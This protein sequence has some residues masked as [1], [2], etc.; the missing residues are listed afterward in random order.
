MKLASVTT[1][2]ISNTVA[3]TCRL[4]KPLS[5]RITS[6]DDFHQLLSHRNLATVLDVS[7]ATIYEAEFA[8][9]LIVHETGNLWAAAKNILQNISVILSFTYWFWKNAFI[10]FAWKVA[11]WS[12]ENS[13]TERKSAQFFENSSA[14]IINQKCI[15]SFSSIAWTDWRAKAQY[16]T[17]PTCCCCC[18][19]C[20][21]RCWWW[22]VLSWTWQKQF[23][24][25]ASKH[26][27]EWNTFSQQPSVPSFIFCINIASTLC[28]LLGRIRGSA[29]RAGQST[30]GG[31]RLAQQLQMLQLRQKLLL[32]I[33][34]HPLWNIC[35][36]LLGLLLRIHSGHPRMVGKQRVPFSVKQLLQ[37]VSCLVGRCF[38]PFFKIYDLNCACFRRFYKTII[39]CLV[40]PLCEVCGL[41]FAQI[42]VT[43]A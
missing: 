30:F 13:R 3:T 2:N 25:K 17:W 21:R 16:K 24:W 4:T 43:N 1:W 33:S 15:F 27:K 40:G 34:F 26:Q 35:R 38:T 6:T 22:W 7:D 5:F 29:R 36:A 11:D 12:G 10:W 28:R 8:H 42:K 32:Q 39:D 19:C 23:Q 14:L 9:V 31:L 18:C 20:C 37:C 41:C